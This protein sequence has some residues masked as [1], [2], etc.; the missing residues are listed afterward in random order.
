MTLASPL[1]LLPSA[2]VPVVHLGLEIFGRVKIGKMGEKTVE[3][4]TEK[5]NAL[6]DLKIQE[7]FCML[8]SGIQALLIFTIMRAFQVAVL[9]LIGAGISLVY[10]AFCYGLAT[11]T[12]KKELTLKVKCC[13]TFVE[14]VETDWNALKQEY[15]EKIE[16]PTQFRAADLAS[17]DQAAFNA[18]IQHHIHAGGTQPVSMPPSPNRTFADR[19][20]TIDQKID[21]AFR[22]TL[23]FWIDNRS[24][25]E[26]DNDPEES[27]SLEK[28]LR[29]SEKIIF[30][31]AFTITHMR[32]YC[33]DL[34]SA[35]S[36]SKPRRANLLLEKMR[37]FG[38]QIEAA[39]ARLTLLERL[40]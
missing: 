36:T 3:D 23:V 1:L 24:D 29:D 16:D 13:R 27:K 35:D 34:G 11:W 22:K 21:A 18:A 12:E 5:A 37:E 38:Q 10:G 9:G 4:L 25:A 28:K 19:L 32:G 40:L 26:E 8:F 39:K 30:K 31:V 33:V 20:K 2:I 7:F 6:K 14:E 15:R 17:S